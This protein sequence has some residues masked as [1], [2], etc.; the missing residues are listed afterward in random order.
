MLDT[1]VLSL[2]GESELAIEEIASQLDAILS[3]SLWHRL[4]ARQDSEIKDLREA[5]LVS[6][7]RT[8]WS[9]TTPSQ[10]KGYF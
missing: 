5:G 10:R 4:L 3:S 2:L 9:Q 8:I 6:R 7:A 1:A